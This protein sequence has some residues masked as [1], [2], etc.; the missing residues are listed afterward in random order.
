MIN[1][2]SNAFV[3][4]EQHYAALNPYLLTCTFISMG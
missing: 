1:E 2:S 4:F 3:T